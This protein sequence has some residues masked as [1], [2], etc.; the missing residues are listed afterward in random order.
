MS[1]FFAGGV[2]TT[3]TI[4]TSFTTDLTDTSTLSFPASVGTAVPQSNVLRVAG[5]NGIQSYQP[6]N[7]AG[8]LEIGFNTGTNTT[9]GI[10]T[11]TIL[12]LTP[13]DNDTITYQVLISGYDSTANLGVGGQI[14][15]TVR[16]TAGVVTVLG[17]PDVIKNGDP[18]TGG[19][20]MNA[21]TF[22]MTASGGNVLVT[23]TSASTNTVTWT[24]IT[25]GQ[26]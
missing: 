24:A 9:L 20:A 8:V 6:T 25:A 10:A 16:K 4:P 5:A 22:T 14:V 3:P 18:L 21:S 23:A 13:T 26:V 1:Q 17:T 19:I 12:T 2:A 11:S 15:A 7:V